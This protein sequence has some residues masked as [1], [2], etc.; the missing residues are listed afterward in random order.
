MLLSKE[1]VITQI[2]NSKDNIYTRHNFIACCEKFVGCQA[3]IYISEYADTR[4]CKF[5]ML[6]SKRLF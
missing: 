5:S 3:H 4:V 2:E 6:H 1:A